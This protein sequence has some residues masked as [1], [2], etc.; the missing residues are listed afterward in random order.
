LSPTDIAFFPY[1]TLFRS[2][3]RDCGTW[4][5]SEKKVFMRNST[6]HQTWTYYEN[7]RDNIFAYAIE[8]AG[9]E[10][11]VLMGNLY[12]LDYHTHVKTVDRKSTRLNYS[13]V[14]ISY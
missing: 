12:E 14:S 3:C 9:M 2:M 5:F 13:H 11:G 8:V 10:K 4:C 7:H 6:A 1:T